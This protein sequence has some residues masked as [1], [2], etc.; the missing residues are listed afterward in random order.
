L[1]TVESVHPWGARD[2]VKNGPQVRR[3]TDRATEDSKSALDKI[4]TR[5][6]D[7][8]LF[9]KLI[10]KGIRWRTVSK[11]IFKMLCSAKR[12]SIRS[13]IASSSIFVPTFCSQDR[14]NIF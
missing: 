13:S 14:M 11:K 9:P 6:F 3:D 5:F 2:E 8:I 4:R 7:D 12:G 10:V 1:L